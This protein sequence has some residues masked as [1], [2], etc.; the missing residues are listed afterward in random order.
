MRDDFNYEVCDIGD[1]WNL[2]GICWRPPILSGLILWHHGAAYRFGRPGKATFLRESKILTETVAKLL[3]RG[4][5][6]ESQP[7]Q[8]FA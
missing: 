1:R 6:K 3:S 8:E 7:V 5:H 2:D 4:K